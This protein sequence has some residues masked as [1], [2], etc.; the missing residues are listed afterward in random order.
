MISAIKAPDTA[1]VREAEEFARSSS[2]E[3]LFNHVMRCYWFAE[4][5]ARQEGSKADRELMFLSST[6]HDL[7]FTEHGRGPHRFEIE[8]AHAAHRFLV[9][10]GV[11]NIRA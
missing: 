6:L 11:P 2:S 4:L 3:M 9:D 8:G 1:I 5:F 7:G 10:R